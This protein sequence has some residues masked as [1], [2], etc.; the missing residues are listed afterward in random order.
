MNF[1]VKEKSF[2]KAAAAIAVPIAL[3]NLISFGVNIA[4]TV[5]LGTFG[6]TVLAGASL[7]NQPFFVFMLFGFGLSSGGSVL[8]A[9]YWGK[10]NID[11]VRRIM[12]VSM[13]Y[14]FIASLVFGFVSFC[15][16]TQL[17]SLFSKEADVIAAG[18]RYLKIVSISY[19]IYGLSNNYMQSLRGVE[20]VKFSTKVY[21][22]SFF[23]NIFF[24]YVYMFGKFGFPEL[25]IA[26]AAVGT[27]Y[28][29]VVELAAVVV[30]CHWKEKQ[31]GYKFK[32]MF[33]SEPELHKD[34]VRQTLPV[35]G[36][37]LIW[38]L[39][40]TVMAAIIGNISEVYTSAYTIANTVQQLAMVAMFG[41]S[42]ATAVLTGKAIGAGKTE[43]SKQIAKT[44]L[45]LSL[46]VGFV[47]SGLVF[48]LRGPILGIYNVSPEAKQAAYETLGVLAIVC[49]FYGLEI[50]SIGGIL[51]GA[52]DTKFAFL[53][54][55]GSAWL[56]AVPLGYVAGHVWKLPMA[57]VY[58]CLKAD[59]PMRII[60]CLTRILRGN[61]I[62]NVTR[63][64]IP[65][66]IHEETLTD[67]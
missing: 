26:G 37:E 4:D 38:G 58:L 30:Y 21:A 50:T 64:Y 66:D 23:V 5:M 33:R 1:L 57:L 20:N 15:F 39:S 62:K 24:N 35:V 61:Y 31:I 11:A 32:Y 52:G 25:G 44:M 63:D 10:N 16:P 29:R 45:F 19:P 14:V 56:V 2:Y 46:L 8:I 18:A 42:N 6:D 53:A 13:R 9:Q 51:R 40:S 7:A 65:E 67:A 47:S 3:Q 54:D 48:A 59:M 55:C 60:L 12:G 34:Y 27:I 43:H 17:L 41:L 28:A 36:S 49:A 22:V